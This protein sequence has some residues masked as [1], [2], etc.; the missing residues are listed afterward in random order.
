MASKQAMGFGD[1]LATASSSLPSA[2]AGGGWGNG[3]WA[4]EGAMGSFYRR[5][6]EGGRTGEGAAGAG[7]EARGGRGLGTSLSHGDGVA[8]RDA[9]R[10]QERPGKAGFKQT[11]GAGL[12]LG[13]G[14][15]RG[16][17]R[18]RLRWRTAPPWAWC[19]ET[20]VEETVSG[21][22]IIRPKFQNSVL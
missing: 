8:S 15:T 2:M 20:E 11:R 9:W 19:R 6:G 5:Q 17:A 7:R 10:G 22:F 14:T 16:A 3:V 18:W 13:G 1:G 4:R 12:V 21:N